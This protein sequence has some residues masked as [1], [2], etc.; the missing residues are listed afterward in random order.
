MRKSLRMFARSAQVIVWMALAASSAHAQRASDDPLAAASDGFGLTKG[1]ESIGLYGPGGIRG[2]DPQAAGNV[3]IDG[4]YFDQQGGLS[5]RVVEGSTVRVG[6]GE[7]GYAF[8][9]PTGIVDYALRDATATAPGASVVAKLGPFQARSFSVDGTVPLDGG[10]FQLP[11]GVSVAQSTRT[12]YSTSNPGYTSRVLSVGA[13]PLFKPNDWLGI[14][15]IADWTQTSRALTLPV[16]FTAG[17][18]LPPVTTRNYYGQDWAQGRS[19]AENYGAIVNATLDP[20]WVLS[21]GVFRS[22]ADAP[23]SFTDL[24]LDTLPDGVAQHA[25]VASPDQRVASTSGEARLTGRFASDDWRQSVTVLGRGRN[26]FALYG[27]S[28]TRALGATRL[29]V[30]VQVPEPAFVFGRRTQD[31]TRLWSGGIAYRA[32]WKGGGDFS[33]GIQRESYDKTVTPPNLP[34]AHLTDRPF[35]AY[36]SAALALGDRLTA[37]TGYT[38]G[39][40]DSGTAPSG[41]ANRGAILADARTWQ[42]D[43]GLRLLL[44]PKLNAIAGVFEINKP[45][46]NFDSR[47]LDRLLGVQRARGL[48]FSVAGEAVDHLSINFGALF[49]KVQIDGSDLAA[50]GVGQIAL[51]QPR[52][53]GSA[54]ADYKFARWPGLSA[55]VSVNYFGRSPASIDNIAELPAQTILSLGGRYRFTV[56]GKPATLRVQVFNATNYYFWNIGNSPG[57]SQ[58]QPRVAVGYLT[59]DV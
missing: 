19:V 27:G 44:T 35:R 41:A 45:Y 59:V 10:A 38:Q 36:G 5:N 51:G 2:F 49:G 26:T 54:T 47:D 31:L 14:R 6:V 21:T 53:Q 52:A 4:L 48:E 20:R 13:T 43:A 34:A 58:F 24:Y 37:Y 1:L 18:Y 17:D 40:E 30:N 29:G 46:F 9:A 57:F 8:P 25:V 32:E 7:I 39:L 12:P 33:L 16:V 15:A 55:D 11:M 3:R 50:Q 23:V 56:Q 22:I 42:A 28:D